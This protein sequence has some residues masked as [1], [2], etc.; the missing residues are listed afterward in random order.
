MGGAVLSAVFIS[1]MT[2]IKRESGELKG[3]TT[4][5]RVTAAVIF[6]CMAAAV[7]VMGG[8]RNEKEARAVAEEEILSP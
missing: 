7:M 6:C 1:L 4:S 8:R 2:V 5:W 3:I